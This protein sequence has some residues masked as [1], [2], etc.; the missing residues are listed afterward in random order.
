[1]D[2]KKLSKI[3]DSANFTPAQGY[4]TAP[5]KLFASIGNKEGVE[6]FKTKGDTS[7]GEEYEARDGRIW[8]LADLYTVKYNGDELK[9]NVACLS[10]E[11]W[12]PSSK[13]GFVEGRNGGK[14]YVGKSF[15]WILNN[16]PKQTWR[17]VAA[18][19]KNQLHAI[20]L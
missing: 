9:F 1:M 15:G 4:M 5:E 20:G 8:T 14:I 13:T 19:I 18:S 6:V 7:V 3:A 12:N 17:E 16:G 11:G 10:N 2:Y